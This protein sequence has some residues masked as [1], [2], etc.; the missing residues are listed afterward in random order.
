MELCWVKRRGETLW[1]LSS[2][3]SSLLAVHSI[4]Q[5]WPESSWE[6][7]RCRWQE[8]GRDL[9]AKTQVTS[10]LDIYQPPR[11]T[12]MA[13]PSMSKTRTHSSPLLFSILL[14]HLEKQWKMMGPVASSP[15]PSQHSLPAVPHC[16]PCSHLPL[17]QQWARWVTLGSLDLTLQRTCEAGWVGSESPEPRGCSFPRWSKHPVRQS[18]VFLTLCV[19]TPCSGIIHGRVFA[20]LEE[21]WDYMPILGVRKMRFKLLLRN[22]AKLYG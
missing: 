7:Q 3:H 8:R 21:R 14:K 1:L 19:H 16:C 20:S 18:R 12:L 6:C 13:F 11:Q 5:E 9:R 4:S 15:S 10:M 22:I 17:L 2:C